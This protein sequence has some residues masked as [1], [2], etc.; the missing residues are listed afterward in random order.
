M[1]KTIVLKKLEAGRICVELEDLLEMMRQIAAENHVDLNRA[2]A[3][4]KR[5]ILR[6]MGYEPYFNVLKKEGEFSWL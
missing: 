5:D 2:T 6:S 4:Q 3:K 1:T